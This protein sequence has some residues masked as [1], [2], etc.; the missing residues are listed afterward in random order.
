MEIRE[1]RSEDIANR[2][3]EITEELKNEDANVEELEQEVK[4]LE[5][6]KAQIERDA[7]TRAKEVE[8]VV[9]VAEEVK[10]F[11]K[12]EMNKMTDVKE[13]RNSKEYIDAFAEYIKTGKDTECRALLSENVATGTVPVPEFVY[14]IV[15]TAWEKEG[16]MALVHKT[17]LKGNLKVGF[18]ISGDDAIVHTEGGNAIDPEALTL[19][20]V[21]LKPVS[22]KKMV[23]ISDEVYDLRGEEFLRYTY[24]ELSYKIA[25]KAADT[26]VEIIAES[27]AASTSTQPAVAELTVDGI[28]LNTIALALGKLSDEAANP[29]IIMNKATWADFKTV[30]YSAS[31]PVDPFEGLRVI[32]SNKLPTIDS[33]ESGDAFV[34]VGDLGHGSIANFPNGDEIQFKFDDLTY[35]A[36]DLIEVFGREYV[37]LGV[38]APNAFVNIKKSA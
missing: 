13:I 17:Y 10:T 20:V 36:K 22:I 11:D 25:K 34:I 1:M 12:E 32:F 33:A 31:V 5:E 7:E 24:D 4:E 6:R 38:V 29:V 27:P 8:A 28:Q 2:V 15:K 35:K 21:E 30:Q 37:G 19:G 9:E 26:L 3:E 23:Q 16:I 18:E 14:D